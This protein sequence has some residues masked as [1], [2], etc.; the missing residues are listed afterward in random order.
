MQFSRVD[1]KLKHG[2]LLIGN[3]FIAGNDIA[4][5]GS[6]ALLRVRDLIQKTLMMVLESEIINGDRL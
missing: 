4:Q 3:L 5:P 1:R 2:Q 6:L